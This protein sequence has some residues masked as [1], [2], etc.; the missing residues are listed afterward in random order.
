MKLRCE[1]NSIRLRL[2]QTEVAQF[3]QAGELVERIEFPGPGPTAL[4]YRLQF[5]SKPGSS[6]VRF[7][8]G[9]LTVSVP[10]D[11][12]RRWANSEDEVGLYFSHEVSGGKPLRVMIEK[13]YQCSGGPADEVDPGGYRNPLT[14]AGCKHD[15]K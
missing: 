11:Q 13:D 5:G 7:E 9:E 10:S 6:A 1:S 2:D 4:I 3:V 14:K 15:T 12:A 8:N